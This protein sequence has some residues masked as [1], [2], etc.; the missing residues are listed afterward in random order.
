MNYM[1]KI[2]LVLI[3]IIL[4]VSC[5]SESKNLTSENW[6]QNK[7][8][9]YE[10]ILSSIKPEYKT[11]SSFVTCMR[12]TVNMCLWQ[13]VNKVALEKSDISKCDD[14]SDDSARLWCRQWV[15][16]EKAKK[17]WDITFC[18]KLGSDGVFCV[19]QVKSFLA[20]SKKDLA[21]CD[22]LSFDN[23]NKDWWIW[24]NNKNIIP[25]WMWN[26]YFKDNC[27]N[28]TIMAVIS[29]PEDEELCSKI[30]SQQLKD[31]CVSMVRMRFQK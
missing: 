10:E 16:T 3:S 20:Q 23:L 13:A 18:K 11:D 17:T 19:S 26:N 24:R 22:A 28:W 25:L 15:A 4:L 5:S 29:K 2:G 31:W 12:S 30:S 27:L 8:K 7:V 14:M 1:R 6:T 21:L 9:T